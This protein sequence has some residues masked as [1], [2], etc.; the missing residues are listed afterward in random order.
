[1][2]LRWFTIGSLLMVLAVPTASACSLLEVPED[3]ARFYVWDFDLGEIVADTT[4]EER[5]LGGDCSL[6]TVYDIERGRLAWPDSRPGVEPGIF[7]WNFLA[8]ENPTRVSEGGIVHGFGVDVVGDHVVH[9]SRYLRDP[10]GGGTEENR[11]TEFRTIHMESGEERVLPLDDHDMTHIVLQDGHIH[12]IQRSEGGETLFVYDAVSEVFHAEDVPLSSLGVPSKSRLVAANADWLVF[13]HGHRAGEEQAWAYDI[14]GH[15]HDQEFIPSADRLQELPDAKSWRAK[16]ALDGD[17]AF[18]YGETASGADGLI[19]RDLRKNEMV[20]AHPIPDLPRTSTFRMS[21][22]RSVY[23]TYASEEVPQD[24][25][26]S[27]DRETPID[28]G[29]DAGPDPDEDKVVTLPAPGFLSLV[30]LVGLILRR[31]R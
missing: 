27:G 7:L 12:W 29:D 30:L 17:L 21:D 28:L 1:M 4:V 15:D 22:G 19:E 31:R 14:G 11:Y 25:E 23:G 8:E 24:V 13:S 3:P 26:T 18:R 10:Q 20:D 2:R 16:V 5:R 6:S 9:H